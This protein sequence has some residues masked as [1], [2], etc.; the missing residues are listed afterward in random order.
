M[1]VQH[2]EKNAEHEMLNMCLGAWRVE[3]MAL[4]RRKVLVYVAEASVWRGSPCAV[5]SRDL[6]RCTYAY[7][8]AA[9]GETP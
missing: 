4:L 9:K 8:A 1:E 7:S 5:A 2:S 6:S 3:A